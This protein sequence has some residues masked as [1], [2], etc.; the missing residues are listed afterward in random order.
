[1]TADIAT[2]NAKQNAKNPPGASFPPGISARC[3]RR[4]EE[5]PTYF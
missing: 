5:N 4:Q 3:L 2:G 1:M